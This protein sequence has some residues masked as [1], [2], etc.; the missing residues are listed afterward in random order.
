MKT[1]FAFDVAA[2]RIREG[3]T[4]GL[5]SRHVIVALGAASLL[6]CGPQDPDVS[7]S[8]G[9]PS[10]GGAAN[11]GISA[12]GTMSGGAASGGVPSAG[13]ASSG[14]TSTA[15]GGI[16]GAGGSAGAAAGGVVGTG[17]STAGASGSVSAPCS[18]PTDPKKPAEKLS[19]TGCMDAADI[20]KMAS[21]VVPYDVN[22]PLWSDAA[23]KTRGMVLP[24]DKKIHV[25]NCTTNPDECF[26]GAADDG[27]WVFPVGSVLVK[28]FLFDDKFVETRLFVN[29][30]GTWVGYGYQWNEQQTEATVVPSEG[31]T[32]MF[33]TGQRQVSWTY[34]SRYDCMLCHNRPG[35]SVL[36]PETRQLNRMVGG[37]NL[38][39]KLERAGAFDAPLPKPYLKALV[40]PYAGPEGTPP[41]GTSSVELA[42]SYMHANCAF[43]HRAD[44]NEG[45]LDLR[46][47]VPL[48]DMAACN[49]IPKKGGAGLA[50]YTILTPGKPE[51]S[52]I[53]ARVGSL[54][55]MARMP[56]IGTY[57]VDQ[58]GLKLI[59]DW[60][61]TITACP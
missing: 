17:G 53:S 48:K 45:T 57:V 60:I 12:G 11:G 47:S 54:D 38:L 9:A 18:P 42:R 51:E 58:P 10:A 21:I 50:K 46:Y 22:S 56:Q 16:I 23:V 28:N 41:Q 30:D 19:Q 4:A 26:S 32:V 20:R 43:C 15:S 40:T 33:N 7:A 3:V 5:V 34:P 36:G 31:A 49:T 52:V 25:K 55:E 8:G 59:D 1:G 2:F 14:G 37:E 6:A 44:G 24:A 13:G 35:G 27:R 39:D 29:I 61:K